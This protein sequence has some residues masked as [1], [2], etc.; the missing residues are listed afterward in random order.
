[1]D[2][3]S[4]NIFKSRKRVQNQFIIGLTS[5]KVGMLESRLEKYAYTW[6][7]YERKVQQGNK[8]RT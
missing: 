4:L 7:T 3:F 1:M 8:I 6:W 2:S 5:L